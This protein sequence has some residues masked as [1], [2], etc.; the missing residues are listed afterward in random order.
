MFA[1]SPDIIISTSFHVMCFVTL[2]HV[3]YLI[4][5]IKLKGFRIYYNN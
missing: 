5:F 3:T 4:C 1:V 2:Y